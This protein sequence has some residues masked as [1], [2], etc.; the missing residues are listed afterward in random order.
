MCEKKGPG[1]KCRLSREAERRAR[2]LLPRAQ[3]QPVLFLARDGAGS[4]SKHHGLTP[5]VLTHHLVDPS[6]PRAA[7]VLGGTQGHGQEHFCSS[8]W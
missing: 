4:T 1:R 7:E 3:V 2:E 6:S 8:R 5:A